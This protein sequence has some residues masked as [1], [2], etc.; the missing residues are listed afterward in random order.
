MVLIRRP[1]ISFCGFPTCLWKWSGYQVDA[2]TLYSQ[3]CSF[4]QNNYPLD[5]KALTDISPQI[6]KG[7][8]DASMRQES[9]IKRKKLFQEPAGE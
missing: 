9:Q 7:K 5:R 1:H 4:T 6:P 2:Q 3:L 8:V